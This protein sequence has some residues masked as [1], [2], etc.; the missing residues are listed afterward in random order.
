MCESDALSCHV[1]QM[2]GM[3][4]ADKTGEKARGGEESSLAAR[5]DM[6]TYPNCVLDV[7]LGEAE[8]AMSNME[9][10]KR[11]LGV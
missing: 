6:Q 8:V 10:R 9:D 11:V 2:D 4:E 7:E 5:H 1:L 3:G